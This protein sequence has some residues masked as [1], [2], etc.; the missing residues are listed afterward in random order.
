MDG[1]YNHG[2]NCLIKTMPLSIQ[3][4]PHPHV[5]IFLLKSNMLSY[6][7]SS[8]HNYVLSVDKLELKTSE[9]TPE[10]CISMRIEERCCNK[11]SNCC[12]YCTKIHEENG[13]GLVPLTQSKNLLLPT[14]VA[15][16]NKLIV[17]PCLRA[18]VQL[19]LLIMTC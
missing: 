17:V 16:V 15:E 6:G 13:V 12:L 5:H 3:Q 4:R 18:L 14:T 2:G 19:T 11:V 7:N 9:I 1:F 10:T 8:L